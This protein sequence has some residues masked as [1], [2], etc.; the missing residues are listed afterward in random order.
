MIWDKKTRDDGKAARGLIA[1]GPY[2]PQVLKMR[3]RLA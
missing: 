2:P 1:S 3:R